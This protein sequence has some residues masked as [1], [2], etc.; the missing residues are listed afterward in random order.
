VDGT[1]AFDRAYHVVPFLCWVANLLVAEWLLR[2]P[3]P[4]PAPAAA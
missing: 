4:L 2:R 1:I 3:R